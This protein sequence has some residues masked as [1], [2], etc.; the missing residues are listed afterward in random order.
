MSEG[1][2]E[3]E[4]LP[5]INMIGVGGSGVTEGVNGV[6]GVSTISTIS[7]S[8]PHNLQ[9]QQQ[10]LPIGLPQSTQ[11]SH[12]THSSQAATKARNRNPSA[13]GP[14]VASQADDEKYVNKFREMKFKTRGVMRVSYFIHI[15][16]IY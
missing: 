2:R 15:I 12:S 14:T 9:Q 13:N 4:R 16:F 6:P 5:P 11:A 8:V 7:P 1:V 3:E 10:Q